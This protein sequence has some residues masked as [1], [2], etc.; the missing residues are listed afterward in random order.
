VLLMSGFT[1]ILTAIAFGLVPAVEASSDLS[2]ALKDGAHGASATARQRLRSLL[3]VAE[4]ALALVLLVGA[5]LFIGSFLSV[6][7]IDPGFD[8]SNVLIAQISPRL[9]SRAQPRNLAPALGELV[10]RAGQLPGVLYASVISSGVPLAAPINKVTISIP[11]RDRERFD[12]DDASISI[13]RVTSDYHRALKIP[14]RAGRRF[15]PQDRAGALPVVILNETAARKFFPD[16][17]AIGQD[18]EIDQNRTIVGVVGDVHQISLETGALP[19][20]YVPIAQSKVYGGDLV[21]K[22]SA[23][24][25]TCSRRSNVP[26]SLCFP[27]SPFVM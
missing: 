10:D 3:V 6:L 17:N 14:V 12:R 7:R 15:E 25:T 18:I 23:I 11:G 20:A 24:R 21:I 2:S 27:M 26:S 13:R 22:T 19:E 5:A 16:R 9:E 1:A 8:S 4:I